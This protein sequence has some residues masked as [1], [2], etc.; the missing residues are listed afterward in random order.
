MTDKDLIAEYCGTGDDEAFNLLVSRHRSFIR[1]VLFGV[2]GGWDEHA[3]EAEQEVLIA[4][5]TSLYR[6][7]FES[8]FLTFLYRL[9]RNKGID[10]LRSLKKRRR[11]FGSEALEREN[12]RT[13][14]PEGLD[15]DD[16]IFLYTILGK[17]RESERSIILLKDIEGFTVEQIA[18]LLNIPAGTAKSRLHRA[19]NRA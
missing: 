1:K 15:N 18:E 7:R 12:G 3:E 8:S 5:S 10:Q 16:R 2:F 11:V 19:R 4:L 14:I 13:L 17:L 6:F 9:T